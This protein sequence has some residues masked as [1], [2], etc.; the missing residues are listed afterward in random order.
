M[1][2]QPRLFKE[3]S[4][5]AELTSSSPT[6]SS[7]RHRHLLR[8]APPPPQGTSRRS[9]GS[10]PWAQLSHLTMLT[11]S[12]L[13]W[14]LGLLLHSFDLELCPPSLLTCQCC[15]PATRPLSLTETFSFLLLVLSAHA[16]PSPSPSSPPAT[17][18]SRL[19]LDLESFPF[20]CADL[21]VA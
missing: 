17:S 20:C 1:V 3:L 9:C 8:P 11:A 18:P 2:T 15:P 21:W 12:I 5:L 13:L 7:G 10:I 19:C 16:V 6:H 14:P 4:I